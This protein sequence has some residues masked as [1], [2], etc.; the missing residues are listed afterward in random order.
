MSVLCAVTVGTIVLNM[1]EPKAELI[2]FGDAIDGAE[3]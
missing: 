1:R 2:P 3:E